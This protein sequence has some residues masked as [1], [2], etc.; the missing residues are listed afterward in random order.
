MH[1]ATVDGLARGLA[2]SDGEWDRRHLLA[3]VLAEPE[4]V[5]DLLAED[6]WC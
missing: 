6:S 4:R 1:A 2:W 5:D 3:A